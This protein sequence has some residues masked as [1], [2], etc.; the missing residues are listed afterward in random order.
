[1][2]SIVTTL[3]C[4]YLPSDTQAQ[5]KIKISLYK[6]KYAPRLNV[7][8]STNNVNYLNILIVITF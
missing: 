5:L 7:L 4:T 1:M 3:T 2:A 8:L 6:E